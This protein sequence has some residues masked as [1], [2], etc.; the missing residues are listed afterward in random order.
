L[1]IKSCSQEK[2]NLGIEALKAGNTHEALNYFNDAQSYVSTTNVQ[3]RATAMNYI[4]IIYYSTGRAAEANS[5]QRQSLFLDGNNPE[6]F[7]KLV[8]ELLNEERDS[9]SKIVA[10]YHRI[11]ANI[12]SEKRQYDLCVKHFEKSNCIF[13][14]HNEVKEVDMNNH[15]IRIAKVSLAK[16]SMNPA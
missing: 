2:I 3:E 14:K 8:T 15:H 6:K 4:S 11:L 7:E 9:E 16:S 1:N 12:S 5:I 10:F 13:S